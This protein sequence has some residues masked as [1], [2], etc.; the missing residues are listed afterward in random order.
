MLKKTFAAGA[1]GLGLLMLIMLVGGALAVQS[2]RIGGQAYDAIV[3]DKDLVADIL[4]PPAYVIEANLVISQAMLDPAQVGTHRAKLADLHR[5]YTARMRHWAGAGLPAPLAG[6]LGERIDPAAQVFWTTVERDLLPA[7]ERGDR[8]AAATAFAR[9][10]AAY[11]DHRRGVDDAV[12]Q[13]ATLQAADERGAE[14]LVGW[15]V[16]A[17]GAGALLLLAALGL[18]AAFLSR[19]V[20]DPM[21]QLTAAMER[22]AVGDTDVVIEGEERRDEIGAM[23]RALA[24]FRANA[25]A[26]AQAAVAAQDTAAIMVAAKRSQAVIEFDLDGTI[27]DANENFLRATGYALPDL[28]G[29]HHRMLVDP[30]HADT[31]AYADFWR[32]LGAGEAV[33]DTFVRFGRGGERLVFDAAYNPILGPDDR[34]YKVVNFGVDVTAVEAERARVQ[35]LQARAALEQTEVLTATGRGLTALADGDLLFRIH[36]DF[37]GQYAALKSDFNTA[38]GKLEDAM[39]IISRSAAEMQSGSGEMSQAADDLSRRTEQQAATLEETAA[40][41][42]QITATVRLTADGARRADV[43]V[44][45]ARQDAETSGQV[46]TRAV[47]AMGDIEQSANQITQIIGVIDEIAF[48]TSLLALNAGVEAARAGDAGRGF[49]VVASEVRALAQR[50]AGAAKEIKALISASTSQVRD[51]VGLVGQTGEALAGIVSRVAEIAGLI[52]EISASAHEQSTALG[53]VN[54]AVNRMDQTTQQNAAMVEQSTAASHNL[55]NE[56]RQL[57]Q[58]VGRFR[59]GP[60]AA[61]GAPADSAAVTRFPAP[62]RAGR[63]ALAAAPA[64]QPEWEEF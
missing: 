53:E 60:A 55:S 1:A 49:A 62:R 6:V 39:A 46:V 11:G 42:D 47:V 7:L 48:Q 10:Q 24:V 58:L 23:A 4:P 44:T 43:V 25:V 17:L 33:A 29:R 9:A 38:M 41:L 32:R 34:P 21:G 12:V 52:G 64:S 61:S 37:P 26:L 15:S 54:T 19:R 14:R 20:M 57:A 31:G 50:S 2:I 45:G 13:S 18:A 51:G 8:A 5:Q 16:A 59:T 63:A 35:A 3:R 40:A 56:A 22:L 28:V 30:A 27:L 36:E